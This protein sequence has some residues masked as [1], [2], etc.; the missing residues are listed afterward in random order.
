[1]PRLP[2]PDYEALVGS[3]RMANAGKVAER[4]S[5]NDENILKRIRLFHKRFGFPE[6]EIKEKIRGDNMFA[7][8]F[9]IDP[10]RQTIHEKIA[11]EWLKKLK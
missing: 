9:A 11:E 10:S 5:Q 6:E 8:H 1:M 7:A 4:L 2:P 3:A